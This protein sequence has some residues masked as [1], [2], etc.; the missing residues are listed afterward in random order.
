MT[1]LD[2]TSCTMRD[3]IAYAAAH[4]NVAFADSLRVACDM[5]DV[6][7]RD[8]RIPSVVAEIARGI[9]G[10][11]RHAWGIFHELPNGRL[12][13]VSARTLSASQVMHAYPHAAAVL[14]IPMPYRFEIV[15]RG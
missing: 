6:H 12:A 5:Y 2:W 13:Y 9:C 8:E 7:A 15:E 10:D 14:G 1:K 3:V 4:K 11:L